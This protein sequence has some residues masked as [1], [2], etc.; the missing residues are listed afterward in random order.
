[1]YYFRSESEWRNIS[2]PTKDEGHV[3]HCRVFNY[4]DLAAGKKL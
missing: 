1:M 4:T 3:D 2:Q